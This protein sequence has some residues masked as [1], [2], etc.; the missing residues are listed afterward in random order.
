MLDI[1]FGKSRLETN[2]KPEYL[3]WG[4]FAEILKKIR[5]TGETMKEYDRM[6]KADQGKIKDGRAFVGGFVKGGRRKKENVENRWLITLD[7]DNADDGFILIADLMLCGTAYAIYSTHS[8]RPKKRKYR[9]II[10]TDRAMTP[11]EHAAVSRK[12]ADRIGMEYFDKASFEVHQLMYLPSCSRDATPELIIEQGNPLEVDSVLK[13]YDNWSDP[14]EWPA[15]PKENRVTNESIKKLGDPP[16]KPGVIGTFCSVY[17][18]A[19]GIERFIPDVYEP[20]VYAD[21][22]TFTGGTSFGG[23]RVY[24]D[25]WAYSVHQSDPANDGH[26]QNI[27]DLIRIHKFGHLDVDVKEFTPDTKK[28][29]YIAMRDFAT[30]DP[31]VKNAMLENTQSDFDV[32]IDEE[33][34]GHLIDWNSKT[35]MPNPTSK[36]AEVILKY[37]PFKGVLAY[38]A[39]GNT[40]VIRGPLP[41]REREKTEEEYEPWLGSDDSRLLHYLGK[42]Y[43]FKS[44]DTIRN[45]LVEV[46][47]ANK[48]HPIKEYIESFTWDGISRVET[49]FIDYL[50]AAD[51]HYTR[52]A[53]RKMFLAAVKRLYEPGC[54]FDEMLVLI[55]AQG[56]GKSSLLAKLGRKWFSDS[57]KTFDTKEAGEH[58]QSAWI[59]E[60]GELSAMKKSEVEEVKAFLSKTEDKYRVAF[61]RIVTNF[62]RKCVFFGTTNTKDFLRDETG[63]RR[64]WPVDVNPDKK[65]YSHW[66]YLTDELVG[67]IWAEALIIY[68]SGEALQLDPEAA[69][70]AELQQNLHME[71]DPREGI[72]QEWLETPIQEF[73]DENKTLAYHERVNAA[74]IW[75]ECLGNK[76]GEV[77]S[78]EAKKICA[79][80]R[81]MPGWVELEGPKRVSGYRQAI[82][83]ERIKI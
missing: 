45:A 62:Q 19:E 66:E 80:M 34:W 47:R 81:R 58:L 49:I 53:T 74:K 24:N 61:D 71:I 67:K 50:G 70:E 42:N 75:T 20:T 30:K 44:K 64:F 78:W 77:S 68:K 82:T 76:K 59:F 57:L 60:I 16:D 13:E 40:E 52:Q 73:I 28:P 69:K 46:T 18:I 2:W 63:N 26:C 29:S 22:W 9:L 25:W 55:G 11:D 79:I 1:S 54:K 56:A 31:A 37:G 51:T 3:E 14:E 39:F 8:S 12:I 65:K 35:Q 33:K 15:H 17:G 72:I 23:M 6:S 4:E 27:F 21:R 7:A 5:I 43:E 48:F 38:D 83:F 10:P 32:L 36:N 41:W